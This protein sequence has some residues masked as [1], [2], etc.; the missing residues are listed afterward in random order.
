MKLVESSFLSY[1]RHWAKTLHAHT[2]LGSLKVMPPPCNPS[3]W[4][5]EP[6][7]EALTQVTQGDHVP[8]PSKQAER[9]TD[10]SPGL[11]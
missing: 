2:P 8:Q 4:E 10:S 11:F 6:E 5:A 7:R 9:L 3:T 1:R